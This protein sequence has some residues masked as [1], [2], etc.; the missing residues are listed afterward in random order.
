MAPELP[1][2]RIPSLED[3]HLKLEQARL[4]AF[5]YPGNP[6]NYESP[7]YA[8]C[9]QFWRI[10]SFY[11]AVP[12]MP[13]AQHAVFGLKADDVDNVTQQLSWSISGKGNNRATKGK[14]RAPDVPDRD[15]DAP[16]PEG[17]SPGPNGGTTVDAH[18]QEGDA[19]DP[20]DH[21]SERDAHAIEHEANASEAEG[22]TSER[23]SNTRKQG[24]DASETGA[25][26]PGGLEPLGPRFGHA[27]WREK[28]KPT[29]QVSERPQA[30][31][32]HP[33][34]NSDNPSVVS[35]TST[36]Q[37]TE[38]GAETTQRIPDTCLLIPYT[39]TLT[40]K[41]AQKITKARVKAN[42]KKSKS[43]D[44]TST[45]KALGKKAKPAALEVLP[46]E[47]SVRKHLR[48]WLRG[49]NA[50]SPRTDRLQKCP[51]RNPI[52]I[53]KQHGLH[54]DVTLFIPVL[55][56]HKVG[57]GRTEEDP[58]Y[59]KL[60]DGIEEEAQL[61]AADQGR[62]FLHNREYF[63]YQNEVLLVATVNDWYTHTTMK[64]IKEGGMHKVQMEPWSRRVLVG[65][66]QSKGREAA[67][68]D[69]INQRFGPKQ[70]AKMAESR[71]TKHEIRV[72]PSVSDDEPEPDNGRDVDFLPTQVIRGRNFRPRKASKA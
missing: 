43:D 19:Q 5:T 49:I 9:I 48:S 54:K 36:A 31:R 71:K 21:A 50:L 39:P 44:Q 2:P 62:V 42:P 41:D 45:S 30:S 37:H 64:R 60:I 65:S 56:E 25:D 46:H 57:P 66:E 13:S 15:G 32:G 6:T 53:I 72:P 4:V 8:F 51:T 63:G 58:Q 3:E 47:S 61:E 14:A 35:S 28:T 69:W 59:E 26:P 7:T 34:S 10:M 16:E 67:I 11:T 18:A 12:C 1:P 29:N 33:T 24:I 68:I 17:H 23:N 55:G 40:L 27:G 22:G 38:P 20:Q 52:P 70:L